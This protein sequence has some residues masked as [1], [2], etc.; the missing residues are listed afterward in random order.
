[1]TGNV[2]CAMP[3]AA[4]EGVPGD[5]GGSRRDGDRKRP[6]HS[7]GGVRQLARALGA[8]A[9]RP[10]KSYS[11]IIHH[12]SYPGSILLSLLLT[13]YYFILASA[14]CELGAP[15]IQNQSKTTVLAYSRHPFRRHTTM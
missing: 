4:H 6:Q 9:C 12:L 7:R 13:S 2:T 15:N 3:P 8:G 10:C 1:M 11:T 14:C 5:R